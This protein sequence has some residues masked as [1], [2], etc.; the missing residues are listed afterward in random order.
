MNEETKR[1][2]EFLKENSDKEVVYGQSEDRAWS[3]TPEEFTVVDGK[4]FL[5]TYE[6]L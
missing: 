1:L 2:I 3:L 6:G 4:L 5:N